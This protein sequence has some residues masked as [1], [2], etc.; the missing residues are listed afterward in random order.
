MDFISSLG[1]KNNFNLYLKN[2]N[3]I[4]KNDD[5]YSSSAQIDGMSILKIDS[6]F[7]LI[8]IKRNEQ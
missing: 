1:F 5:I 6:V 4:A 3:S 7:P 2:L 8:K